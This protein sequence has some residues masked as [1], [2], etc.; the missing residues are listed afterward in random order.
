M[1]MR[2]DLEERAQGEAEFH[3]VTA[4]GLGVWRSSDAKVK[5]FKYLKQVT[6]LSAPASYR[7]FVRFRWFNVKGHVIKRADRLTSRCLQPGAAAEPTETGPG[8]G[9]GTAGTGAATPAA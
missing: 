9:T 2:V 3:T 1:A 8:G 6:N 5:V 4:A 7:G